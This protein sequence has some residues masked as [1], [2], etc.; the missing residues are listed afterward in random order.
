MGG[1]GEGD[2]G[3]VMFVLILLLRIGEEDV[4]VE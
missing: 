1:R 2:V 3:V 4:Y